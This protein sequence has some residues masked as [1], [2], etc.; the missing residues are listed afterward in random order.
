MGGVKESGLGRRHGAEGIRRYTAQRS[1]VSGPG[2]RG[3]YDNLGTVAAT[4]RRAR[5]LMSAIRLMRHIPGM[6]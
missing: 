1:I 4:P 5:L 2:I 6:R 3:G